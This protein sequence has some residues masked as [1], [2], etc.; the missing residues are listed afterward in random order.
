M[1]K[2][3]LV[4]LFTL[5]SVSVSYANEQSDKLAI[6]VIGFILGQLTQK[7]KHPGGS[8]PVGP[9]GGQ[10][11]GGPGGGPSWPGGGG[12]HPGGEHYPDSGWPGGPG[13]GPGW[14][15]GDKV[16]LQDAGSQLILANLFVDPRGSVDAVMLPFCQRPT[17][18]QRVDAVSFRVNWSDVYVRYV[19]ITYHNNEVERVPVGRVFGKNESSNWFNVNGGNRCIKRIEVSG[20]ASGKGFGGSWQ[21]QD[22]VL[23]FIGEKSGSSF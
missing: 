20:K 6:G 1:F 15:S 5:S 2:Y 14:G 16:I 17:N 9:G 4:F 7:H 10:Y 23:T 18:N 3:L 22:A 13:G 12:H 21:S 8:G 19:A 11:P